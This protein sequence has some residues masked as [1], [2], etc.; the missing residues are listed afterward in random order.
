MVVTMKLSMS[1]T[2]EPRRDQSI[3]STLTK[4]AKA[5]AVASVCGVSGVVVVCSVLLE[6]R[7]GTVAFA[8]SAFLAASLLCVDAIQKTYPHARLGLANLATMVRMGCVGVLAVAALEGITPTLGLLALAIA[9][10][11]LDGVD[12]WFA[13]RQSLVSDF[14]ARFDVEVDAA[15]ALT[16]AVLAASSG[17]TGPYV[18]LLGV[19]HYLFWIARSVLPWLNASLPPLFSRKAICVLQIG[20]LIALLVSQLAGVLRDGVVVIAVLSLIWSFGRDIIWLHR[21]RA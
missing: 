14:G 11:C 8:V 20:T 1:Q 12:G 3:A 7:A 2:T 18:I 13:R 16:L 17:V 19:P 15:F 4:P 9:S 10:L 21:N 6:A 5:F